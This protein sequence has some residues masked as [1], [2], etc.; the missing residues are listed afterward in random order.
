MDALTSEK[1][2]PLYIL[3]EDDLLIFP[4]LGSTPVIAGL[5]VGFREM[6]DATLLLLF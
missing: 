6:L 1:L 2:F 4:T 3:P 5:S